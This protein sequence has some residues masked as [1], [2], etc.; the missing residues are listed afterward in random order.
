MYNS[1]VHLN[2]NLL[3]AIEVKTTGPNPRNHDILQIAVLPLDATWKPN[4][5][6]LP[7]VTDIRP[8]FIENISDKPDF[9]RPIL[10]EIILRGLT[11]GEAADLFDEWFNKLDLPLHKKIAPV[12]HNW[13]HVGRFIEEWVGFEHFKHYFDHRY[14]DLACTMLTFN[15]HHNY[16]G[17]NL[18]YNKITLKHAC[19]MYCIDSEGPHDAIF[20]ASCI[21]EAYK[22]VIARTVLK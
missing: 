4:R 3:C 2:N 11:Y 19:T 16:F 17:E 9:K 22:R 21:A 12:S 13:F 18:T 10:S 5:N 14:R 20:D 1:P 8:R 15:D 6:Y 7:F